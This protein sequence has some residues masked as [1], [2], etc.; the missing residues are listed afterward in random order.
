[1]VRA[2]PERASFDPGHARRRVARGVGLRAHCGFVTE[3]GGNADNILS[4]AASTAAWFFSGESETVPL[5]VPLVLGSLVDVEERA[6]AIESRAFNHP[7]VKTSLIE[8]GQA[9]W[10]RAA[11]F[12]LTAA[13]VA[14]DLL[15][16]D[17]QVLVPLLVLGDA[18]VHE[19][20]VPDVCE[21]HVRRDRSP[22]M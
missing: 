10:E 6:M 5:A 13:I 9:P 12:A 21:A 18:E 15:V 11:R 4:S 1:M 20:A 8:I 19:R 7:G 2:H 16:A 22:C 14:L 3:P 17:R